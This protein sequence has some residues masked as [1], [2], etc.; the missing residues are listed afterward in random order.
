MPTDRKS[1]IRLGFWFAVGAAGANF[2]L[3]LVGYAAIA[4]VSSTL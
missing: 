2:L 3:S 4:V 1:L